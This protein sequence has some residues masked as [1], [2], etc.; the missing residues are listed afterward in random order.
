MDNDEPNITVPPSAQVPG[1]SSDVSDTVDS[2][3]INNAAAADQLADELLADKTPSR[4]GSATPIAIDDIDDLDEEAIE[5]EHAKVLQ[6][7]TKWQRLREIDAMNAAM[8]G[9]TPITPAIETT[10]IVRATTATSFRAPAISLKAVDAYHGKTIKE[11]RDFV[12]VN[13]KM[14]A[15]SP[16]QFPT[17]KDKITWASF[18][19]KGTV[20]NTWERE[21]KRKPF[22]TPTEYTWDTWVSWLRDQVED[23]LNRHRSSAYAYKKLAQKDGQTARDFL[24]DFETLEEDMEEMAEGIKMDN[25]HAS[26]R[27][28]LRR[29]INATGRVFQNRDEMVQCATTLEAGNAWLLSDKNRRGSGDGRT[30]HPKRN[31]GGWQ[32][33]RTEPRNF[34]RRDRNDHGNT[35]RYGNNQGNTP[36]AGVNAIQQSFRDR[37]DMPHWNS[38]IGTCFRCGAKGHHS[39]F[40]PQNPNPPPGARVNNIQETKKEEARP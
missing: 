8:N 2:T 20:S 30:D 38:P 7:H 35:P 14:H 15:I 29:A 23:P 27:D 4:E 3:S 12:T 10:P 24:H 16:D 33:N 32:S 40:C 26:L 25:F 22:G 9:S 13:R 19:L 1:P 11:H 34:P 18:H 5:R 31:T 36:A 37:P 39:R 17:D 28:K 21:L 6:R